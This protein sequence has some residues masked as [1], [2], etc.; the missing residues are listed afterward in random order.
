[1]LSYRDAGGTIRRASMVGVR[2]SHRGV[3][4][5]RITRV[6]LKKAFFQLVYH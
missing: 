2:K 5:M 4:M 3:R 1:M 6:I